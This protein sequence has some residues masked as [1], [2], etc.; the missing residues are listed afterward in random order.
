MDARRDLLVVFARYPEPGRVKTR[1]ARAIGDAAAAG[2]YAAFIE[3][4]ARRFAGAP[5][6]VRW[7][8]APPDPGFARRFGIDAAACREQRGED[9]GERMRNAFE[10]AAADGFSRVALVGSDA[11][12]LSRA[13]VAQALDALDRAEVVLGPA[14][15]G[16]YTLI[17]LR[18][19]LDVF[20]GIRWSTPDVL[21]ETLSRVAALGLRHV[22]LEPDF[23]VDEPDDLVRLSALLATDAG[24]AA[25]LPATAAAMER[26]A[27]AGLSP[28]REPRR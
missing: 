13:T 16:G 4:L 10:D 14:L 7:A 12:Q 17:A 22:L 20:T 23:D 21:A 27:A 8:V 19:P 25:E 11:P 3:D 18:R 24:A 2:L 28:P 26:I 5:W 9:L 1:L 15:D 6:A